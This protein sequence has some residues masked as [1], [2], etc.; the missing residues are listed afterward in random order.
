MN[1]NNTFVNVA[2]SLLRRRHNGV[3]QSMASQIRVFGPVVS[4][5]SSS[6]INAVQPQHQQSQS[7]WP[8]Q[9]IASTLASSSSSRSS[10]SSSSFLSRWQSPLG[11]VFAPLSSSVVPVPVPATSASV[12]APRQGSFFAP[13]F[14]LLRFGYQQDP[15]LSGLFQQQA[16]DPRFN[17]FAMPASSAAA[18]ET[19]DNVA[20][21]EAS[22]VTNPTENDNV[23]QV[24]P[25]ASMIIPPLTDGDDDEFE[26][27]E[28][29]QDQTV[30]HYFSTKVLVSLK[31]RFRAKLLQRLRKRLLKRT[32]LRRHRRFGCIRI[33]RAAWE[34]QDK[35]TRRRYRQGPMKEL[36]A[37]NAG[38][39]L[40]RFNHFYKNEYDNLVLSI[41]QHVASK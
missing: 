14:G 13:Q 32:W 39:E 29:Y 33:V 31:R 24:L 10:S 4:T 3:V 7:Q 23:A 11:Q 41:L 26:M 36:L 1:S 16:Q 28:L 18:S 19:I 38:V 15:R 2:A 17:L 21:N 5:P 30:K 34:M 37:S 12:F 8:Q 25:P 40:F 27:M 20:C 22:L 6:S 9:A 35:C